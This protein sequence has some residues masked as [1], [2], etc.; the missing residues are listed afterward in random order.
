MFGCWLTQVPGFHRA[1]NAWSEA[2]G[3]WEENR[4][5]QVGAAPASPRLASPR[6]ARPPRL[7]RLASHA[8]PCPP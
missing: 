3:R 2:L 1:Y 7:A 6:L 4:V 5:G 8:S